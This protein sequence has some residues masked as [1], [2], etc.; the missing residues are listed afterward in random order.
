MIKPHQF[1]M[2]SF[3]RKLDFTSTEVDIEYRMFGA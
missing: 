1:Y 3:D 2:C